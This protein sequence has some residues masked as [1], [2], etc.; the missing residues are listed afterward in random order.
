M[1]IVRKTARA[2][3]PLQTECCQMAFRTGTRARGARRSL[4]RPGRPPPPLSPAYVG[5]RRRDTWPCVARYGVGI[6][7]V[8]QRAGARSRDAPPFPPPP[9]TAATLL[10][11]YSATHSPQYRLFDQRS[12]AARSAIYC[13]R[14]I[15]L[16]C[17]QRCSARERITTAALAA[18]SRGGR[19]YMY[20]SHSAVGRP[21]LT[22]PL[23]Y[24]ARRLFFCYNDA[25]ILE[26]L[27]HRSA[28]IFVLLRLLRALT[29]PHQCCR[30][31]RE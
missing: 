14:A 5:A 11:C 31:L 22:T 23:D 20:Q 30:L 13:A 17:L 7:C 12:R 4:G 1:A 25:D 8:V 24:T 9:P 6:V 16:V 3:C 28:V 18:S 26:A 21:P 15:L 2:M 19:K 27:P 29:W 10:L